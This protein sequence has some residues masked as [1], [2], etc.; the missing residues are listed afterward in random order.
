MSSYLLSRIRRT[1]ALSAVAGLLASA[2]IGAA[3]AVAAGPVHPS[4]AAKQASATSVRAS[5][6]AGTWWGVKNGRTTSAYN[7]YFPGYQFGCR[8]DQRHKGVDVGAPTGSRSYAWGRGR[9]VGRGYDPGGYNRWIQVYFPSVNM[10]LTLGHL[11]DGSELR[12]GTS[13]TRN[14][15]WAK[16]GTK[17]DGLNHRHIH[18]RA[19]RG[20]HGASPIGPCEDMNPFILWD[21]LGLPS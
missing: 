7:Q 2:L 9:V 1:G 19:A 11:L 3:P 13:F 10:S 5:L 12:V 16:V 15:V 6:P 21:A 20:N 17:A 14:T 18:F 8:G 4:S